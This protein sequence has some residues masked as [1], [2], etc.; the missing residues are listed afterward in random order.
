MR[1]LIV[2]AHPE[3]RSFNA[4]M[5]DVAIAALTSQGYNVEVSDLYAM[6]F[7]PLEG[8]H[9][10]RSPLDPEWFKA[11]SEQRHAYE[12]N[13]VSP[14]VQAEIDKLERAQ[15]VIF[16]YPMWWFSMPAIL[17]GWLDRVLIYGGLYTSHVRYD[18]GHFRGRRAMV[19]ITTG[20][21]ES[22]HQY[23]G[24]NGDADL[25]LWPMNFTLYY[26]GY[27]VL[28][29]FVASGI[30]GGIQYSDPGTIATRLQGHKDAW[31]ERLLQLEQTEPLKFNGWEDWDEF[32][33][34][35]P[36]A[37]HYSPFIRAER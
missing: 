14:D 6:G 19:S 30:E 29:H 23:N 33:R 31:R 7:D 8:P 1:A 32:G 28:P 22:T 26:M 35:R 15:I 36:G 3:S 18:R 11:Q 21:P 2:L 20:A 27:T 12:T 25:L 5:K 17:K 10:Y 16:Q 37:P 24:R 9:H 13:A 34:L 4:Q